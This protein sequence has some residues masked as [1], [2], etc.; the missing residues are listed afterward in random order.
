MNYKNIYNAI[1]ESRLHNIPNGYYEIHHIKPR[2][3]GGTNEKSNL[4]KLLPKEHF[5]CH[6][7]LAKI[8]GGK[9][10]AALAY[11]ARG[12]TKSAKHVKVTSRLYSLIKTQ[13]AA[14]R[15][16][17]YSGEKNPFY[18]KKHDELALNK[19][20]GKRSC[21]TGELSPSYKR[22]MTNIK[23]VI[24]S[25]KK[26]SYYSASIDLTIMHRI[27]A[28]CGITKKKELTNLLKSYSLRLVKRN[29]FGVNNPNYGN[30]DRIVGEKNPMYGKSHNENTKKLIGEK[31]KRTM[32]CPHCFKVSN[33]GNAHR[34]HFDNCKNK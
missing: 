29:N 15:S 19:M 34:W 17:I 21:I 31:S 16:E 2:S 12:N 4:V 24:S 3:F 5:I 27:N 32:K 26:Y 9:M 18:N 22:D 25:V 23:H 6:R 7:L 11:M 8:H 14:Y 1:I 20:R 30:G 33:I 13:D 10:W 28:T